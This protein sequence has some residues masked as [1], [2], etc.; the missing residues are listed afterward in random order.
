[1]LILLNLKGVLLVTYEK[2]K[3]K[4]IGYWPCDNTFISPNLY[5]SESV[6]K[7]IEF[8]KTACV[9]KGSSFDIT[10][11]LD[12]SIKVKNLKDSGLNGSVTLSKK[13]LEGFADAASKLS[14]EQA[15]QMRACMKPYIDKILSILLTSNVSSMPKEIKIETS[16]AY[17]V[18]KEF[19][20]L[21]VKVADE[22][23]SWWS[24]RDANASVSY[25]LHKAKVKAYFI[26]A[27]KNG[28]GKFE[29]G[30]SSNRFQLTDKGIN[31]VLS[32]GLIN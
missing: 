13:E 6:D 25:Q 7:A 15:T 23:N 1:M 31:Y 22:P 10:A 2:N 3:V 12:G 20:Q 16:G 11:T 8:L 26:I 21:M 27:E 5:A 17:F 9:T 32:R 24:E 19:D 28:L 30:N 14:A 29:Y 18:T 4:Q